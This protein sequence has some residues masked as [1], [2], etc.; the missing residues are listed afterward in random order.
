MPEFGV[1]TYFEEAEQKVHYFCFYKMLK[2][3]V[4]LSTLLL[5]IAVKSPAQ[6]CKHGEKKY[7]ITAKTPVA[8]NV[9]DRHVS[10]LYAECNLQNFQLSKELFKKGLTGY[11][12]LKSQKEDLKPILSI[13]DFNK[14]STEKRLWIIDLS[15]KKIL[16]HTLV[17]HG[18]NSGDNY[19]VNFSNLVNSNMSSLGFYLTKN[20]YFGKHGLSLVIEGLDKNINCNAKSRAIVIHG[21]DYVSPEFIKCTGRLGRSHG[22]PAI[23][24]AQH[25]EIIEAIQGGSLLF[26][27]HSGK[28]YN[29][30]LLKRQAAI[31]YY[32][33]KN[34]NS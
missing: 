3:P 18:K 30:D 33:N 32:K 29:S 17:A 2:N 14:P 8:E 23:P 26:I 9:F 25:K 20:T 1:L 21:A 7:A 13:I 15:E 11:Y 16:F 5:F 12:N 24:A 28:K 4:L 19:T 31:S 22:C 6:T 27:H 34:G 10:E